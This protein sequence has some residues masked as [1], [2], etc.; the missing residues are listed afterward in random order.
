MPVLDATQLKKVLSDRTLLDDVTLTIRRGEKVG[1]VGKNGSGKSTLAR[2]LAGLEE[3]DEGRIARRRESTVA[4]LEQAPRLSPGRTVREVVLE[5]LSEWSAT[6][7]RF[8][9]LTEALSAS[10]D[11]AE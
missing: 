7:R 1:L 5:S 6:R 9:S 11:P 8:E 4:Y 2:V 3:A 10:T